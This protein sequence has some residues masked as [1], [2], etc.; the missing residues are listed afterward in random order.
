MGKSTLVNRIARKNE[1]IVHEMRGVTRDRSY[2]EADWNGVHFMLIDT[3]GIDENNRTDGG[4]F[5]GFFHGVRGGAG[6]VTDNGNLLIRQ[7]IDQGGFTGVAAPEKTDMDTQSLGC[8]KP[9]R[10]IKFSRHLQ[11]VRLCV[12]P[13]ILETSAS[14]G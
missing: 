2:H 7:R 8:F 9:C 14:C 6:N 3:G 1:A 12:T 10:N 11:K 13:R 4:E 5:T